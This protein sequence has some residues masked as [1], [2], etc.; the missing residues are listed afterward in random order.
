MPENRCRGVP[1]R[2]QAAPQRPDA[3]AIEVEL[4]SVAGADG[5]PARSQRR[6]RGTARTYTV[7]GQR[8][9]L[10][11]RAGIPTTSAASS[12]SWRCTMGQRRSCWESRFLQRDGRWLHLQCRPAGAWYRTCGG[13][14]VAISTTSP[15]CNEAPSDSISRARI[16]RIS[17]SW[18]NHRRDVVD[19]SSGRL[20]WE[21]QLRTSR[22]H[23]RRV[24]GQRL[25]LL[26]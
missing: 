3:S 21:R 7:G 17:R 22:R 24:A 6:V 8:G 20:S 10:L 23:R 9:R 19:I 5:A 13:R 4:F 26:P 1:W 25:S 2:S 12:P 15:T 16:T 18:Q 14:L 11:F